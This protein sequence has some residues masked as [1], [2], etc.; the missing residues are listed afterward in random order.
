[1]YIHNKNSS[2]NKYALKEVDE[3]PYAAYA[4]ANNSK[5]YSN[6]EILQHRNDRNDISAAGLDV[7]PGK[8]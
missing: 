6:R 8:M 3:V 4:S 1:M 7:F 2:R 5:K